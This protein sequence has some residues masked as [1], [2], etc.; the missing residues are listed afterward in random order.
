MALHACAS[1]W[2]VSL[3]ACS[4]A[5]EIIVARV[6]ESGTGERYHGQ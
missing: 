2:R 4:E 1:G 5:N 6:S 3:A